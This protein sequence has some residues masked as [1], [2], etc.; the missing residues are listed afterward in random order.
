MILSTPI[1]K[2]SRI[3]QTYK[4][5][6]NKLGIKTLEDLVFHFPHRYEDFSDITPINQV[7]LNETVC[8]QGEIKIIEN[9]ITPRKRMVLTKAIVKDQTS[10]IPVIWFNQPFLTKNL[11][12]GD[13]VCLAGKISQRET[14]IYLSNPSYEKMGKRQMIHTGR[15]IP[16]YPETEGLS[17]RWL[18]YILEPILNQI[19]DNAPEPIPNQILKE[20]GLLPINQAVWQIHFPDS[21]KLA[22]KAHHRFSFEELLLLQLMVVKKKMT[23]QQKKGISIPLDLKLIKRFTKSLPFE[24]TNAQKKSSWKILK[25]MEKSTPMSRLLQGDVGSGKTI[26]AAMAALSTTKAK[27]QTAFMAPTEILAKQHFQE[28]CKILKDSKIKIGL[29][30]SKEQKIFSQKQEKVS[31]KD[32]LE[33]LEKGD[34]NILIGT[35]SLIQKG[36]KFKNLALVILDEQHRFGT[37]QRAKLTQQ[38]IVPHFLSMTATPIPRSLALTVYGDLDL[39]LIDEMP[40][41]RKKIITEII[42][43]KERKQAYKFIRKQIDKKK[44]VFV[45]C[46]RIEPTEKET[47]SDWDD[48]KAVKQEYEKLSKD[49]FPDLNIEMLHGK[50]KAQEKEEIMENFKNKKTNILVST[51]VIEVGI[52]IPNATV[53][54]IEG[55]EKFG[56]A[57]LHQFRGRVGRSDDQS[58]CFLFTDSASK[59]TEQRL[60]SLEKHESGFDLAEKDLQ[61]RGA[62]DFLG[63]RQS[64]IPDLAMSSLKDI[65]LVQETRNIAKRILITDLELKKYPVLKN[66]LDSFKQK[67]HL[68]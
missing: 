65:S 8:I 42:D 19:K 5:K 22:E 68:E 26:V 2:V 7:K 35:H 64:G 59:K 56:L 32:F 10:E 55:A 41:G 45:V 12:P 44:Q 6:L 3:P 67:I 54:V 28:F 33:Q 50:M 34:I 40:K 31:K 27:Y 53:M 16:V 23:T 38:D 36:V 21:L 11:N 46:P 15:I 43:P 17:S 61:I 4:T 48:V 30:T 29:L 51:S 37:N 66:R 20:Q 57:Q 49:I 14:E 60:K 47:G 63:K 25:E 1:Q 62:G 13:N 58:Y 39:S 52:D 9:D 18:R 24:L